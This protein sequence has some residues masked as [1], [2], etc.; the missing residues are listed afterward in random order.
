MATRITRHDLDGML[1]RLERNTHTHKIIGPSERLT[2]VIGSATYGN[3]YAVV[4]RDPATGGHSA[5]YGTFHYGFTARDCYDRM[6]ALCV[7]LETAT[8]AAR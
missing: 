4:L 2:L 8:D 6:H 3:S 5:P 1:G 7:A